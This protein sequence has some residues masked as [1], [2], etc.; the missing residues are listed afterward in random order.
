[1]RLLSSYTV[2]PPKIDALFAFS[3][4]AW[5][6]DDEQSNLKQLGFVT[7]SSSTDFN[8]NQLLT[9]ND[10]KYRVKKLNCKQN[11]VK[12]SESDCLSDVHHIN[13]NQNGCAYNKQSINTDIAHKC[14][15]GEFKFV[16]MIIQ[17]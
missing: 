12:R 3:F 4:N 17:M 5:C 7:T 9:K 11:G 8:I 1:M 10:Q 14:H 2:P 13:S 16:L 6:N 15:I